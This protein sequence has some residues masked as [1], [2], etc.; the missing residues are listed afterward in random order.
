MDL[1]KDIKILNPIDG[2]MLTERDG[3]VVEGCLLTGIKVLAPKGC[4]IVINGIMAAFD[5]EV[6][7][8]NIRLEDYSNVVQII[9][10]NCGFKYSITVYWLRNYTN[11][12]RLSMDDN[13]WFLRDLAFNAGNYKSIF[14]N[15]YLG[16][17]KKV[18][19]EYGTKVHFN[20]YYG[21]E[22]FDITQ[23]PVRFKSEWKDNS[24]WI[25]LSFHAYSDKPD[26]PYKDASYEKA[27]G[28]CEKVMEQVRRFA[29]DEVT[30]NVTTLHWADGNINVC[31]ALR[32]VGFKCQ[33]GDFFVDNDL[34]PCSYYLDVEKRRHMNK[35]FIWK[36]NAEDIIF[37]RLA[38]ITDT[39]KLENIAPF[40]DEIYKDPL[41][42][43]YMDFCIHE[44]YFHP[45]YFNYQPDYRQKVLTTVRWAVE[46]G[47][48]PAF[49]GECVFE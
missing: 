14:E 24:D 47:Y 21:E 12:Y 36:D 40:L 7:T 48:K 1:S 3:K 44:Q 43:C 29:G 31:R 9:E 13:I 34:P 26:M 35:R 30:G 46:K 23:V 38:I 5:G 20:I 8:A 27:R 16:F 37:T 41:K 33:A 6:Y 11:S 17:F 10:E 22:G 2:D 45:T 28:D 18:H 49:L 25:R 4:R 39:H 32:D 42:S 15:P 19:D